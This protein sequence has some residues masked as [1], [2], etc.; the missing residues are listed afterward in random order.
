[1]CLI[2]IALDNPNAEALL[3]KFMSKSTP[4]DLRH[5]YG[6][7]HKNS[8][9]W[10]SR[11]TTDPPFIDKLYK[12][13]AKSSNIIAQLRRIYSFNVDC[14]HIESEHNI[15]NTPPYVYKNMYFMH[16]G[17]L[18]SPESGIIHKFQMYYKTPSFQVK[19]NKIVDIIGPS[20]SRQIQGNTDSELWFY[21]FLHH[22]LKNKSQK[23]SRDQISAAFINSVHDIEAAGF[24]NNSNI[25]FTY[26]NFVMFANIYRTDHIFSTIY[27]TTER[28][29][30][31]VANL[32][33]D[34][35]DG[36][37]VCSTRLKPGYQKIKQNKI[38]IYNLLSKKLSEHDIPTK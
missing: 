12:T 23:H 18:L 29:H 30:M 34:V 33:A 32:Y 6:I 27:N 2:F 7:L 13:T 3:E 11:K 17:N 14:Q 22:L 16:Q 5:G 36:V 35:S 4:Y 25:V 21:L 20:L 10:V 15:V 9:E 26:E 28:I 37:A 8:K 19:I 38:Y 24:Q 31:D 1:M